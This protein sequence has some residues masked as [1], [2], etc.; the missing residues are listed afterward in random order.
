[1]FFLFFLVLS[2]FEIFFFQFLLDILCNHSFQYLA[3]NLTIELF[4]ALISCRGMHQD[5]AMDGESSNGDEQSSGESPYGEKTKGDPSEFELVRTYVLF[6]ICKMIMIDVCLENMLFGQI[7][8]FPIIEYYVEVPCCKL[9][10]S[11]YISF[12]IDIFVFHALGRPN[13]SSWCQSV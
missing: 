12:L 8:L 13:R 11:P 4:V 9:T 10:P 7:V 5:V 1:M 3:D 6:I 2:R